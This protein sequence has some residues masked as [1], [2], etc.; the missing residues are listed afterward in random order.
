MNL[1][2]EFRGLFADAPVQVGTIT[3]DNGD[4]TVVVEVPQGWSLRIDGSGTVGAVVYFERGRIVGDA[5][6][7][8]VVTLDV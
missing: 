1:Y 6:N 2:R 5:P 7:L 4:G 8:S 3:V